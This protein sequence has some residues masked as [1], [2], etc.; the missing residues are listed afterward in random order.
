MKHIQHLDELVYSSEGRQLLHKLL[1][2]IRERDD[3]NN[4]HLN[5]SRKFDG[6]PAIIFGKDKDGFFLSTKSFFNVTPIVCRSKKEVWTYF[7]DSEIVGILDT[8]WKALEVNSLKEGDVFQADVMFYGKYTPSGDDAFIFSPNVI[9]YKIPETSVKSLGLCVHTRLIEVEP[10]STDN[11]VKYE[12][13]PVDFDPNLVGNDVFLVQCGVYS[14]LSNEIKSVAVSDS[15]AELLPAL[16][17]DNLQFTPLHI[18]LMRMFDNAM[19]RGEYTVTSKHGYLANFMQFCTQRMA[20]DISELKTDISI[21]RC[22]QKYRNVIDAHPVLQLASV[23]LYNIRQELK[24]F[25]LDFIHNFEK[26][27]PT[28]VELA[29]DYEHEGFVVYLDDDTEEDVPVKFV[30][31]ENFSKRNFAQNGNKFSRK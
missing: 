2:S 27:I 19:I 24:Q 11:N 1:H 18:E 13:I 9:Q 25:K 5:I 31:R 3:K 7:M 20:K 23:S 16:L 4:V 28:N 15:L 6:A 30:D 26:V 8:A 10:E 12:H 29:Y 21:F 17:A 22:N 14:I